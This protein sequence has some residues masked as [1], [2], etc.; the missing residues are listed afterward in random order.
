MQ[1]N[2]SLAQLA[3]PD[4]AEANKIL[5]ACVHC[6][7]CTATCPTYVLL[8]DELD[9]PRGRIYL[10]KE[11][12]E[13]D[14]PATEDVVTHIDRCLS[15]LACMTT[16]PSGV[17]YMHLVD[18]AR[19]HIEETYRRPLGDRL[20][21]AMLATLMVR[22]NLFRWPLL[23]GLLVKPLAP[24]LHSVGMTRM[25]AMLRLVPNRIPGHAPDLGRV[26]A[27]QGERKGRVALLTGC[28]APV[29]SPQIN[30]AAV[31]L[32]TRHGVDVVLAAGEGCCGSMAHHMGR[33]PEAL[34]QVRANVDAW[35][36]EIDGG[37]LDAIVIT[38]SGCGTTVKDYG[39]MLRNDLAYAEKAARVS[40]LARDISEYLATLTLS[41]PSPDRP[42]LKV[43]YH[44]ACSLQHGQKIIHAPKLLLSKS[45]FVVEDIAEG[46]LCCG[47]AGTYNILQPELAEQLRDRKVR[48]IERTKAH[49]IAAGNVG[50]ITQLATGTNIPIVHPVELIDWATG[51]PAP[52][53]LDKAIPARSEP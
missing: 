30:D 27:G 49:V 19:V 48:N 28:V 31:R 23:L 41:A 24:L 21:R 52:A 47:S 45:G 43:A 17:H 3:D 34:A 42:A 53:A 25:A 39:F 14:R 6:G 51:G 20:L 15:C 9:S 33:E 22:P 4:I 18:Q 40:A 44:A 5:R 35:I 50:C 38:A 1:T 13:N 36:A 12:L 46:H 29:V 2:F 26:L 7:F 11:M 32:L 8:G 37:G 16:C 10:I